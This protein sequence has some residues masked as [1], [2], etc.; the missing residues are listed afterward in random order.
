MFLL[1]LGKLLQILPEKSRPIL[2]DTVSHTYKLYSYSSI[3]FPS[4]FFYKQIYI[5][6]Y[7]PVRDT[8]RPSNIAGL[9]GV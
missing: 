9:G 3:F 5:T 7:I 4:V 6:T 2:L 1:G 8:L